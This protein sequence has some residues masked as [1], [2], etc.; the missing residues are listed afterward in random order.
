MKIKFLA[1]LALFGLATNAANASSLLINYYSV[2]GNVNADFGPCCSSP[3]PATLPNINVGD[4]LGIN[5]LPVSS[6]GANP[7]VSINPATNE[8][9]WWTNYTGS[10]V[11][12][13][14]YTDST[15]FTPNGTGTN[16]SSSYQ[17]AIALGTLIGTGADAKLSV[18][19]DDDV[20]VYLDGHYVG[21]VLG[22]HGATT[23][24]IDLGPLSAQDYS[25][26]IF[27]ADRAQVAAVFGVGVD[28][29]TINAVPEPSTW[30]MMILGF[31]GVG[32]IAYRRQS[33][34]LRL[35]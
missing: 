24:Q 8:I 6:G 29:A 30:A 20:M 32:F 12:S 16:N 22:V 26:K 17:T 25:L 3:N 10:Q 11:V 34:G 18:T 4:A 31:F 35:A 14:P 19:G 2:P 21:G 27:Y 33:Q 5:G 28:G 7:V 23:T 9:Q 15:M 13:L 1:A